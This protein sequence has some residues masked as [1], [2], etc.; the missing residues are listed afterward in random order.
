MTI[1]I[2]RSYKSQ[3][4]QAKI[5]IKS[6]HMNK[7]YGESSAFLNKNNQCVKLF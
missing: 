3:F 1:M 4:N 2:E 5:I 6:N 7:Y